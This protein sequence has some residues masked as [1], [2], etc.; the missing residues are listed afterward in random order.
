Y[1]WDMPMPDNPELGAPEQFFAMYLQARNNGVTAFDTYWSRLLSGLLIR[2]GEAITETE[3][4]V[5][6]DPD[7]G[8]R[9]VV[10]GD[11]ADIGGSILSDGGEDGA[12]VTFGGSAAVGGDVIGNNTVF[13]FGTDPDD[14]TVIGG[15]V[16]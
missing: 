8:S 12:L 6:I 14:V 16:V 15:D 3:G 1:T 5:L 11:G 13:Q 9:V 4:D 7:E 2:D 10:V